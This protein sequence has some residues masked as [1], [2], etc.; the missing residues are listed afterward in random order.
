[1]LKVPAL[2][3]Y[4]CYIID[5]T[6]DSHICGSAVLTVILRQF[7]SGKKQIHLIGIEEASLNFQAGLSEKIRKK[8]PEITEKV[9]QI[10][11]AIMAN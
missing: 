6:I 7:G 8:L 3:E 10:I 1:M 4:G 9:V 5:N 11:K 2:N